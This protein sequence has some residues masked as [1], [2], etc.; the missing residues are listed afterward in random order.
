MT[1][2]DPIDCLVIGAGPA[3]LATAIYL[4]RFRR[5]FLVMHD[6]NSRAGWIPVTHNHAGFP[7]GISGTELLSRMTAQAEKY[8]ATITQG[9]LVTLAK[10]SNGLFVATV[11]GR[12]VIEASTVMLATGVIDIEPELPN[13]RQAVQR[14]LIR[15]C[16]I[17][18]GYEVIDKKI[19][20]IGYGRTGL[21]E[22]LFLRN[23]SSDITLLS[24]GR[25]L[26]LPPEDHR[27][28]Q[29]AGIKSI[30]A[31]VTEVTVEGERI[32]A[33]R[34][35]GGKTHTFDSLYSA[36]GSTA[37]SGLL[38]GLGAALDE[39]QCV[40]VDNHQRSSIDGLFV[41]GD[42]A[43]GLDQIAIAMGQAAVAATTIH[44]RLRGAHS[45]GLAASVIP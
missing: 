26:S 2:S 13:L 9:S 45:T 43:S 4:A 19:G 39:R 35:H 17:C 27:R 15:H 22:A 37:R 40:I 32:T 20:V 1:P 29:D 21:G 16:G 24:L 11:V 10:D 38:H 3:G 14:G 36:L 23:Y 8:G 41:A 7:D 33:L 25:S 5:R 28:M 30:E 18:D 44:N 34:M 42:V 31:A 6:G 12:D